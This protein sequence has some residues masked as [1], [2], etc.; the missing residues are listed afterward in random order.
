MNLI[1]GEPNGSGT[2]AA[3]EAPEKSETFGAILGHFALHILLG[4]LIFLILL[5]PAVGLHWVVEYLA[6]SHIADPLI[7]TL[8]AVK[9]VVFYLDVVLYI[10]MLLALA[11]RLVRQLWR[12]CWS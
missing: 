7:P 8:S 9:W 4:T 1:A 6:G 2:D 5:A 12:V 11:V 3:P 10:L